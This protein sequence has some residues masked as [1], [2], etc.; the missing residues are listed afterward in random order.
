MDSFRTDLPTYPDNVKKI[1]EDAGQRY[2]LINN[3][4]PKDIRDSHTRHLIKMMLELVTK[5]KARGESYFTGKTFQELT[6][7]VNEHIQQR[8][9][10]HKERRE[11]ADVHVRKAIINDSM[12]PSFY[13]KAG[14]VVGA[15]VGGA[16]G[17]A[18]GGVVGGLL[19]SFAGPVGAAVCAE[20]GVQLGAGMSVTVIVLSDGP[21]GLQRE[22]CRPLQCSRWS[23]ELLVEIHLTEPG[24]L[25]SV[26]QKLGRT[27]ANTLVSANPFRMG[28]Q[29]HETRSSSTYFCVPAS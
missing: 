4:D 24:F 7:F 12:P 14:A 19:C 25:S 9:E 2:C 13:N 26:H 29:H 8:M 16:V 5:N 1:L 20:A 18:A 27:V 17:G 22:V 15:T 21:P 28:I 6:R 3:K 23:P 11:E 10:S